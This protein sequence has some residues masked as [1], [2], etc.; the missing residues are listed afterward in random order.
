MRMAGLAGD[1][2]VVAAMAGIMESSSGKDRAVPRPRRNVLRSSAFFVRIMIF[3]L[4]FPRWRELFFLLRWALRVSPPVWNS[5]SLLSYLF[6]I[7]REPHA[8][9][10]AG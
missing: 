1:P 5:L 10:T 2:F 3:S 7:R 6:E 4:S 9:G 8:S